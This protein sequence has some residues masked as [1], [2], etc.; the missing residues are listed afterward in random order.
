MQKIWEVKSAQSSTAVDKMRSTLKVDRVVAELLLQRGINSYEEAEQFFNPSL[1][2]L[3]NPFLM[4]DMDKAVDALNKVIEKGQKVLLFGDYDVDGTTAVAMMYT[5]LKSKCDVSFY[6]PNRYTEGYGLSK[7]GIDFAVDFGAS[8]MIS[9][10]CGIKSV[11]LIDYAKTQGLEFI[12]CDH[13]EPGSTLPDC[14]VL[15]PKRKDCDYP[16]KEL[17]GC[18]VGFKLLQGWTDKYE[19][20]KDELEPLLDFLALSI[21]ADLVEVTGENRIL[22]F[23]GLKRLNE[24]PR[25]A[26]KELLTLAN[27]KFPV[28]L[29][30]VVF[31]IAPRINAAGRLRSGKYAVELMISEDYD[32]IETLAKEINADNTERRQMDTVITKEALI[33]IESDSN[34]DNKLTTVVYD[35]NWH[36]GVVGIVASRLIEKFYR[37]TIVLAESNGEITGSARSVDGV[38]ILEALIECEALLQQYGGHT[39]A[40]GLTLKPENLDMFKQEF[41][42]AVSKQ[43]DKSGLIEKQRVDIGIELNELFLPH[44]NRMKVPR[45]K[46]IL[47]RLEPHGPGNMQPVFQS[48]NLYSKE[49]RLLKGEH[50]KMS[51]A[52]PP[53]DLVIDAIGFNKAEHE[54]KVASGVPFDMVYTLEVNS[55]RDRETLQLNI[56]DIRE[57]F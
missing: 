28:S 31:T 54:D 41:D 6:I 5:F 42:K 13:H 9:L 52:Q 45:L 53:H 4:K 17:S 14:I 48:N 29:T 21:G 36:K 23:H 56:R 27:R 15:D 11:E 57:S 20:S 37:P 3:H 34:F 55:W 49:V 40:A 33:Q 30:D 51:I 12:V 46:R 44:E 39:H 47:Q 19:Q 2:D 35:K 50:L 16:F 22:A 26:F 8:L 38:N 1:E 18:G 10:D 7:E 25:F 43:I 24:F 32:L